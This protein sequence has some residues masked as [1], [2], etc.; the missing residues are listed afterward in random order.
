[1]GEVTGFLREKAKTDF[2]REAKLANKEKAT[3]AF[4]VIVKPES[5][6]DDNMGQFRTSRLLG[7]G[8]GTLAAMEELCSLE[9][10]E[11]REALEGVQQDLKLVPASALRKYRESVAVIT[12]A[13]QG[14][15]GGG[16][17]SREE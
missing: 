8:V 6:K 11:A 9:E 2:V 1:M 3:T 15:G 5:Y 17:S 4:Q 14:A 13:R 7:L 12:P 10:D 16:S